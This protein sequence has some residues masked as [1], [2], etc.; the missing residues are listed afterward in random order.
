MTPIIP[1]IYW[2]NY[3]LYSHLV[4]G[5][6]RPCREGSGVVRCVGVLEGIWVTGRWACAGSN[7]I[8]LLNLY[9]HCHYLQYI[10]FVL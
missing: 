3:L 10:R 9:H 5:H 7:W 1:A 4:C 6:S 8:E 2:P